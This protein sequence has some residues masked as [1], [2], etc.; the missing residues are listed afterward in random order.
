M[1][2]ISQLN[3][4]IFMYVSFPLLTEHYL[5][6]HTEKH[7]LCGTCSTVRRDEMCLLGFGGVPGG[8]RANLKTQA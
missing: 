3:I 6:D 2:Q 1:K 5:V 4:H 7:E 8:G